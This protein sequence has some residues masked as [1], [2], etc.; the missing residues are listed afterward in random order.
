LNDFW[1]RRIVP[2]R[3][4][5]AAR[6]NRQW[7][8]LWDMDPVEWRFR[9]D[10]SDVPALQENRDALHARVRSDFEKGLMDKQQARALLGYGTEND[11]EFARVF[12]GEKPYTQT[13]G[14]LSQSQLSEV[15]M[16]LQQQWDE[17]QHPRDEKGRF[18]GGGSSWPAADNAADHPRLP[19]L[20]DEN[21]AIWKLQGQA[22]RDQRVSL[23]C[24]P[25]PTTL[26]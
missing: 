21:W 4:A 13:E 9:F 17:S 15:K 6:L 1:E 8:P 24:W 23:K 12:Y 11:G 7:L 22:E 18:A 26:V 16:L 3:N 25:K 10:Y 20:T 2:D 14:E 5:D 19:P